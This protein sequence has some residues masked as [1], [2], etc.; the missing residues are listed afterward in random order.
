MFVGRIRIMLRSLTPAGFV[1]AAFLMAGDGKGQ[2]ALGTAYYQSG[3]EEGFRAG[4]MATCR[5]AEGL[6]LVV[7]TLLQREGVCP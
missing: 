6:P 2:E 3:F 5:K 7:R 1:L 4:Q